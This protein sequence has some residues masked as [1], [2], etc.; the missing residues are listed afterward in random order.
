MYVKSWKWSHLTFL[1]RVD[2]WFVNCPLS[3][4]TGLILS[5][6]SLGLSWDPAHVHGQLQREPGITF[7]TVRDLNARV[8][9]WSAEIQLLRIAFDGY[10]WEILGLILTLALK[11][12]SNIP[13]RGRDVTQK[14][15]LKN[16]IVLSQKF[17]IDDNGPKFF[18][19][20]QKFIEWMFGEL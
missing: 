1:V 14:V 19:W 8:K 17:Y 15:F 16:Y 11:W 4:W 9:I 20:A 2:L 6:Y 13:G 18:L 7:H 3:F 12:P 5:I 10:H